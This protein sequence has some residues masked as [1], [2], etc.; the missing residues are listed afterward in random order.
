[1]QTAKLRFYRNK[2]TSNSTRKLSR[3][4]PIVARQ[5]DLRPL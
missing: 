3:L 2:R 1:M 4:F 5:S